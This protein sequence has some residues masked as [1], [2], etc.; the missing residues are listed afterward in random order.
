METARLEPIRNVAI[1]SSAGAGNRRPGNCG[2]VRHG[3]AQR[4][5]RRASAAA[6]LR[7]QFRGT[8]ARAGDHRLALVTTPQE[9]K[10]A[11]TGVC[12]AMSALFRWPT[13]DHPRWRF[14]GFDVK[15]SQ[16]F[17]LISPE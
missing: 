3:Q 6:R 17:D 10:S 13:G 9:R 7:Q 14:E 2:P 16:I 12:R 4:S 5:T 1:I 11:N 15:A 8:V